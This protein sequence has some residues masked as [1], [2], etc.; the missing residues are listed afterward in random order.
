MDNTAKSRRVGSAGVNLCVHEHSS[1]SP[2]KQSVV[3]V[4]GY[5]DQ[6]DMW[7]RVIAEVDHELLH[8]VTY[9]VRGAGSSDSPADTAGYRTENLVD[10]L[11][12]VV[13]ETVPDGGQFHLVGHDWGSVQ[14]WDAVAAEHTDPRL[15]GRVASFTSISGPSLDHAA[16]LSRNNKGRRLR[17]LAQSARSW[18]IYAFHL[19]VLPELL[20]SHAGLISKVSGADHIGEQ[21]SRNAVNGLGLYRANFVRRMRHPGVLRTDV[22]VQVVHP[23]RDRF[24]S[25]VMLEDLDL[26]CSRLSVV[27]V[28]AGHWFPRSHPEQLADLVSDHIRRNPADPGDRSARLRS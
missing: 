15:R 26:E 27:R 6:Q 22:P 11:V 28:D 25:E 23:T 16:T 12:A 10:D 7:G 20:W 19:P 14:L 24:V 13:H 1:W 5:P 21:A 9:D 17:L 2:G 4:H 8:I 3:L 18:Y